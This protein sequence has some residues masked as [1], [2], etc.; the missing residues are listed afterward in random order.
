MDLYSI[1]KAAEKKAAAQF[2]KIDEIAYINTEKVLSAFSE[3]RV[4][5]SIFGGTTGYGYDDVGR[6]T[7]EKIY[8]KVFGGEA[9]LVRLNIVNGSHAIACALMSCLSCGDTLLSVTG[10]PY[11]TL[12]TLVGLRGKIR[13]TFPDYGINYR[14]V[15]LKDGE[16]DLE[17]ITEE[18][19]TA[20]A[21]FIQRS[22]GYGIR[23]TLSCADIGEIVKAVKKSNSNAPI[24]VDN[25]YGEFCET[26]EPL[27]VGADLICGSLIKNP[28]G[29]LA[30]AG[31]YIAGRADLVEGAAFRLTL[32]GIG[33]ECGAT[34]GQ[35]RHLYQGFFMAPH[36]TAQA[37]KTAVFCA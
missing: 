32:P 27:A 10:A 23:R 6:D 17:K 30:P 19:K 20:T 7:L 35:N 25:C 2:E 16:P 9:A 33:G 12:Q 4:S 28:G 26:Q 24:I 11:D 37:L 3:Y 29:G 13:G 14:Q 22:R 36:I 18:A 15:D 31:G 21:V 1:A 34:F 8:A 5:D